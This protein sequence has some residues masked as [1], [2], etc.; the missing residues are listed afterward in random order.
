MAFV[1]LTEKAPLTSVDKSTGLCAVCQQVWFVSSNN[2]GCTCRDHD[3]HFSI[4]L[5]RHVTSK[6]FCP[7]CRLIFSL[8]K[9]FGSRKQNESEQKITLRKNFGQLQ[10]R[11]KCCHNEDIYEFVIQESTEV[12]LE[13][14]QSSTGIGL[15]IEQLNAIAMESCIQRLNA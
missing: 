12:L 11:V 7:G 13:D 3:L 4:G 14:C 8:V 2:D 15:T 5:L 1:D 6:N 10:N 9:S